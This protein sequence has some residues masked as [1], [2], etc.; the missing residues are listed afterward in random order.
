MKKK[1]DYYIYRNLQKYGNCYIDEDSYNKMG[2]KYILSE[3]KK[4]DYDCIIN[5]YK[6]VY[7]DKHDIPL[8]DID[9]IIE[10]K[11]GNIYDK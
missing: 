1:L 11:R 3:L 6:N 9:Y 2:E 8:Y 5:C 7:Y 10:V 4:K